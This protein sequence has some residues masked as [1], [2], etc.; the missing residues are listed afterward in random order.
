MHYWIKENERERS[1]N[2]ILRDPARTQSITI[3][4]LEISRKRGDKGQE[5]GRDASK[6]RVG[7]RINKT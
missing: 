5:F 3:L 2:V 1:S 7:T 4:L 6:T